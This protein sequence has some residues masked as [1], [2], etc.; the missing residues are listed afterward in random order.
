MNGATEALAEFV[1]GTRLE[2]IPAVVLQNAKLMMLDTFGVI[3]A[4]ARDPGVN[5]WRDG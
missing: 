1:V 3:L 2:D 5:Y 4:G